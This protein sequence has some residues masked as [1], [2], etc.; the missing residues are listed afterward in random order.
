MSSVCVIIPEHKR[1]DLI[2]RQYIMPIHFKNG[3]TVCTPDLFAIS[4]RCKRLKR[5]LKKNKNAVLRKI[6]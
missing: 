4:E 5:E 3:S 1:E 6:G 2:V